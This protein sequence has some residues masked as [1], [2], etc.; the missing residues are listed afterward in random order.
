MFNKNIANWGKSLPVWLLVIAAP[1]IIAFVA[2][3]GWQWDF[4]VPFYY[5]GRDD[6]WQLILTKWLLDNGWILNNAFLGA[7]DIAHGHYNSAAQTSSIH[8][9]IMKFIGVFVADSVRVQNYYYFLNFSLISLTAYVSCRLLGV[10]RL[11]AVPA[12]ILFALGL[13]RLYWPFFA[14]IPNYF[15]VPLAIVVVVWCAKGEYL[16][17]EPKNFRATL[18]DL[19]NSKKFW[20]SLPLVFLVAISDGYY[21]FFTMLL[22]GLSSALVF[23]HKPHL[24]LING[25]VPLFFAGLIMGTALLVM[26]P[27]TQYRN[28]HHEE[29]FPGGVQDP[30][31]TIHPFE[32][33]VYATSLKVMLMPNLNHQITS[34]AHIG[35]VMHESA[36]Q[37]RKFGYYEI[38]G[39]LGSLAG[40][41]FLMLLCLF[42]FPKWILGNKFVNGNSGAAQ[43]TEAGI[44][45]YMLAVMA[46]FIFICE[47]V[48][49]LGS[50]I[51]FA[52]PFIRA[53][54]RFS[55][56]LIFIV[57]LAAAFFLTHALPEKTKNHPIAFI[58]VTFVTIIF[59]LDQIPVNLARS[60][61]LPHVKRFLAERELVHAVEGSLKPGDMVY[62]Y[63]YAQYMDPRTYYGM[64]SQAQMRS[65]L[66]SHYLRW[67]NGASKNSRVDIWHRN[68]AKLPADE[69]LRELA[70]YG[71]KGALVDRWVV[72]DDEFLTINSAALSVGADKTFE[73]S[74]AEMV[75]FKFPDYGFHLAMDKDFKLPERLFIHKGVPLDY[76]KLPPYISGEAL[77]NILYSKNEKIPEAIYLKDFPEL[78]NSKLFS[79]MTIGLDANLGKEELLGDVN[80]A[81]NPIAYTKTHEAKIRLDLRNNSQTPRK[82]NSGTRP[83][84]IG[85]HITNDKG[86][87]ITWDNG[88]R[89]KGSPI[90]EPGKEQQVKIEV[91]SLGLK[92]FDGS[93]N[94]I[95]FEFLQEGNAWFGVNP[96]N[97]VCSFQLPSVR[98]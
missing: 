58:V 43:P 23:F 31:L 53:Y 61:E 88:Y 32:A 48:G 49:G 84:T 4:S 20:L 59:L 26:T 8:S 15:M 70:V 63:P 91:A 33:E 90:L 95:V 57:L 41:G 45:L 24:R 10:S 27:L 40:L 78:L 11:F 64:G 94:R 19:R 21:A 93:K 66:H 51:A 6:T 96:K 74:T 35:Q 2:F 92:D 1:L 97:K 98:P 29:F 42:L 87:M 12:G 28:A 68:L 34:L 81:D 65:Y 77:R 83:I 72:K 30:S 22:L 3:K 67:S 13:T 73:N 5:V 36:A 50:L 47:T 7:P 17:G 37:P 76:A 44:V 80:C 39:Q 86:K 16:S 85:Y 55:I 79:A 62:Q 54:D 25:L 52:Y 18:H 46:G 60:M 56:F 69:L 89:I 71:F 14:F 75:Y 38:S 9:I 82:L